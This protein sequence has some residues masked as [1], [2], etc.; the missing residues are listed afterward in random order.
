M[1]IHIY[2]HD[3]AVLTNTIVIEQ[4]RNQLKKKVKRALPTLG[5]QPLNPKPNRDWTLYNLPP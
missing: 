2:T 1:H 5:A 3:S 4:E